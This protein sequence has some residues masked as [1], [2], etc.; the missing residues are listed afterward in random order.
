VDPDLSGD[1]RAQVHIHPRPAR[2]IRQA[3]VG[4]AIDMMFTVNRIAIRDGVHRLAS[5]WGLGSVE[6]P[7]RVVPRGM[8]RLLSARDTR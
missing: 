6:V 1:L 5:H 2:R 7:V 8:I 3:D 4:Y